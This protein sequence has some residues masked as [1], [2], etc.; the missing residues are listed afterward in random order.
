MRI[1]AKRLNVVMLVLVCMLFMAACGKGTTGEPKKR[2]PN[3]TP[4]ATPTATPTPEETPT[5]TEEPTPTEAPTPTPT[6]TPDPVPADLKPVVGNWFDE[7]GKYYSVAANAEGEISIAYGTLR[8]DFLEEGHPEK[9]NAT[10]FATKGYTVVSDTEIRLN[11]DLGGKHYSLIF[12]EIDGDNAIVDLGGFGRGYCKRVDVS[13]PD[14]VMITPQEMFHRFY[15]M[16]SLVNVVTGT[17]FV[18][19]VARTDGKYYMNYGF[20]IGEW[21]ESAEMEAVVKS[22][23]SESYMVLMRSVNK[24]N[25]VHYYWN[26]VIS[27]DETH[28][29]FIV[30]WTNSVGSTAYVRGVREG[31]EIAFSYFEIEGATEVKPEDLIYQFSDVASFDY[32]KV[33]W[34]RWLVETPDEHT[35][36]FVDSKGKKL[37]VYTDENFKIIDAKVE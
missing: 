5:P 27:R 29:D 36:V 10:V 35:A 8:S 17:D 25:S 30:P 9:T 14:G 23:V 37:T 33:M 32:L 31:F 20:Y 2:E 28:M 12:K 18:N 19:F 11:A 26:E 21:F 16:W 15:G 7:S 24:D 1:F 3:A 34:Q 22:P 4:N 6:P 13:L